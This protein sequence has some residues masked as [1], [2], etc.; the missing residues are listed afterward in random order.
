MSDTWEPAALPSRGAVSRARTPAAEVRE[1]ML[2]QGRQV[3][4]ERGLT[5]G[6]DDDIRFEDLIA[7]AGVPRSSVWRIWPNKWAFMVDV[8]TS[9]ADPE[10]ANLL[11]A[12]VDPGTIEMARAS[13]AANGEAL[14]T[15]EGRRAVLVESVRQT[16]EHNYRTFAQSTSWRAYMAM[17]ATAVAIGDDDART[18][19]AASLHAAERTGFIA[20]MADFYSVILGGLGLRLRHPAY[21][22]EHVAVSCAAV[23]EGLALRAALVEG[24]QG[25]EPPADEPPLADLLESHLP[26]PN[27]GPWT[28]AAIALLGVVDA[29]CEPDPDWAP[30]S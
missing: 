24:A 23:V 16:V 12:P 10:E 15:P 19:I 5:V 25:L 2:R 20:T 9:A 7:A 28:T 21:T 27:D 13:L 18:R 26:G 29:F 14:R 6:F 8:L 4:L 22:F 1:R 3:V 17:I 30:P 11:R